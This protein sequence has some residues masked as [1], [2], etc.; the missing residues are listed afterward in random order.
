MGI[1]QERLIRARHLVHTLLVTSPPGPEPVAG[2]GVV[3]VNFR[4]LPDVQRALAQPAMA[5]A[6]QVI[7]VDNASDPDAVAQLCADHRATAVLLPTNTG[8]AGGVNA[9][10]AALEQ[11]VEQV[12]LLNPDV[13][14]TPEALAG[15]R[16]GLSHH[17]AVAPLLVEPSGRLQ[18]GAAGGPLTVGAFAAYFLGLSHV[19][20]ALQG[21][22][23][24]RRQSRRAQR[25]AWLSM[26]CLCARR[27][28]F[29]RFGPVPTDELVYAEDVAWGTA[30]SAR[31]AHLALLPAVTVVHAHGAAGASSAWVGSLGRLA[32]RR[33]GP[34]RGRVA[35]ALMRCG[36]LLRRCAGRQPTAGAA[37]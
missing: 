13:V 23:L 6:Q 18:V 4:T 9:G 28:A 33:L 36:L 10:L 16:A 25:V 3:L 35:V 14:L 37:D 27:S 22:M 5:A 31:G 26:A 12:L 20:P 30:A 34:Q 17:D 19:L 32:V 29:T 24:T 1:D 2:L 7:V 8:F 15:L 11:G 21:V